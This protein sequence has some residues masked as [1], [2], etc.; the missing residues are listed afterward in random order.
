MNGTR[1]LAITGVAVVGVLINVAI[2][3]GIPHILGTSH[4]DAAATTP[5]SATQSAGPTPTST[6]AAGSDS[7][8]DAQDSPSPGASGSHPAGGN[9]GG[10]QQQGH[11][12]SGVGNPGGGSGTGGGGGGGVKPPPTQPSAPH[13]SAP[14]PPPQSKTKTV[15]GN[16]GSA[17]FKYGNG[18]VDVVGTSPADGYTASSSQVSDTSVIVTF[19]SGNQKETISA[20][21]DSSGELQTSV[22]DTTTGS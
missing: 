2:W 20:S 5:A 8:T 17:T 7:Q 9:P 6:G 14:P 19:V 3:Y 22:T 21:L 1:R 16:H 10:G 11:G 4:A 15:T 13:T 12:G 18:R